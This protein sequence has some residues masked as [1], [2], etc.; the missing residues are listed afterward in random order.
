ML[1]VFQSKVVAQRSVE[2]FSD[3]WPLV[4]KKMDL[5]ECGI[6]VACIAPLCLLAV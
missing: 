4:G 1:Q 5:L 6:Q 2:R 3:T